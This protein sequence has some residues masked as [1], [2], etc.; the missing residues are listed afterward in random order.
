[1]PAW[2]RLD[3]HMHKSIQLIAIDHHLC[4]SSTMHTRLLYLALGAR[5]LPAVAL[6]VVSTFPLLFLLL[7]PTA[8]PSNPKPPLVL[9]RLPF[10]PS[11]S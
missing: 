10:G 1:M 8:D 6:S 11:E 4:I 5:G 9:L 3:T 7:L 2:D